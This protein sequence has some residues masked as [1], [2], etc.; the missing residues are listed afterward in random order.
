MRLAFLGAL[1]LAGCQPAESGAD[2]AVDRAEEELPPEVKPLPIGATA[3]ADIGGAW[4]VAGVNGKEIALDWGVSAEIETGR[5]A[6]RLT[7]IRV[8]SQCIWFERTFLHDGMRLLPAPPPPPPGGEES[9]T[10]PIVTMCARGLLPQEEAMKAAL[11][12][13]EWAYRLPDGS[14]VLDGSAGTLTL[15]T[16]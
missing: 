9:A 3:P 2:N 7:R 15:F 6:A 13:A 16:Q 1:S 4:R 12:G 5:E 14:L 8:Q 10:R 11:M